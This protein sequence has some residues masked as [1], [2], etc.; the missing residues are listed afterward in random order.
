MRVSIIGSGNVATHIAKALRNAN[1]T[2]LNIWSYNL[3]NAQ[4]LANKVD[5]I[6]VTKLSQINTDDSDAVL[7]SVKDDAIA[8]VASQLVNYSGLIAHTSGAVTIDV[9]SNHKN[10]GV[11]Y[12]LQT[13]SK[14]KELDFGNVPLCLEANDTSNLDSL[15][16]L[17]K[18]ISK[19]VYEVD[20]EQR[21]TL[22]LAAVFACNFPNY[23]Y[24]VAQQLL[25]QNHLDFDIIKPL[26]IETANKIQTA[27]PMEVQT[28]P[29]VRNDE[30]TLKK[31]EGMLQ[32]HPEWLTIYKL[33]S[34]QI[35]KG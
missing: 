15:K 28:G 18:L 13:F 21:K 16:Q 34:E 2:L 11:F 26:I 22:H 17:A 9:L 33:L 3:E 19:S 10:Y 5:A 7:I 35:K 14:H 12:P 6:A 32:E 30:Q 1:V 29:A 25:A 24:G 8:T 27:L 4:M 23:L 20:S 31:H